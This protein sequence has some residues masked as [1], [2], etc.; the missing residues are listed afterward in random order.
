MSQEERLEIAVTKLEGTVDRIASIANDHEDRIRDIEATE[1]KGKGMLYVIGAF[2]SV[3]IV[4]R[5]V[6]WSWK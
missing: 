6:S 5:L 1:N 4:E 2:F 3:S